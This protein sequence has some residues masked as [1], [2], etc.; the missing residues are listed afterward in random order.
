MSVTEPQMDRSDTLRLL[1]ANLSSLRESVVLAVM[2]R[3]KLT[4]E[5]AK[6]EHLVA[7]L[8]TKA[9]LSEKINN[10]MLAME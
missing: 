1:K 4:D 3:N 5:V 8:E 10:P 9:L 6:L 2:R 7:D